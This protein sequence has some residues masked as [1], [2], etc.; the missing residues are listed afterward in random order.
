M[1]L[2]KAISK[3]GI[4]NFC[5]TILETLEIYNPDLI[6]QM[7]VYY[8]KLYN[9]Y[10]EYNQTKGGDG[11][12]LGY[13]MTDKQKKKISEHSKKCA[14][15][16]RYKLYCVDKRTGKGKSFQNAV[17]AAERLTELTGKSFN[18]ESIRSA[19]DRRSYYDYYFA[20]SIDKLKELYFKNK[21]M[22][23]NSNRFACTKTTNIEELLQYYNTVIQR[24][25]EGTLPSIQ[26]YANELGLAKSTLDKRNQ[27]LRKLGYKTPWHK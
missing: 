23:K 15:D 14:L 17:V 18:I 27:K 2:Y 5:V 4:E 25:K 21:E 10:G 9:S 13:K 16:G 22:F 19:K 1:I 20:S 3:Y 8:I 11:G 12:V 6:D 7:E 24:Y 26:K